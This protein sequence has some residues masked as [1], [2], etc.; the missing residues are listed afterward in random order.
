MKLTKID[1][2]IQSYFLKNNLNYFPEKYDFNDRK[3]ISNNIKLKLNSY[4]GDNNL[5]KNNNLESYVKNINDKGF[6]KF[7]KNV[8]TEN[9]LKEIHAFLKN[10]NIYP[11][12]VPCYD[13]DHPTK[14][15]DFEGFIASYNAKTI[16][17]TPHLI[18]LATDQK[19]LNVVKDYLGCTPAIFDLNLVW[20]IGN[21][22][23]HETDHFHR[24]YDDFSQ[25]IFFKFK[26]SFIIYIFY[27]TF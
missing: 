18:E 21:R 13:K 1:D 12:H 4:F 8:L 23:K 14:I 22:A 5:K 25:Y 27:I 20:S 17:E 7:E 3:K 24:D 6:F 15:S 16:I 9:Q 19:I 26:K 10:E 2:E 11:A